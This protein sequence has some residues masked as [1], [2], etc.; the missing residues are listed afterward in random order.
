[1]L[2]LKANEVLNGNELN[3]FIY[4]VTVYEQVDKFTIQLNNLD[5]IVSDKFVFNKN[6]VDKKNHVVKSI[7][8]ISAPIDWLQREG[9]EEV[10]DYY[11]VKLKYLKKLEK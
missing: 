6:I 2:Y 4:E 9:Y 5:R 7:Q 10:G 8:L 1:M 3:K 11:G